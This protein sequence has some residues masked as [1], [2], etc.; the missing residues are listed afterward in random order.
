MFMN[1]FTNK[2]PYTDFHELNLDFLLTSYKHLLDSLR[3]IDKWIEK[4]EHDYAAVLDHLKDLD[5]QIYALD[6]KFDLRIDNLTDEMYALYNEVRLQVKADLASMHIELENIKASLQGMINVEHDSMVRYI[7]ARIEAFINS[8]PD[9][10]DLIIYNPVRGENTLVQVA[11]NDLYNYFN[12]YG[13]T[14]E[15]YDSL[16][17]TATEYDSYDLTA[18]EYD[19]QGYILLGYPDTRWNMRNPFNGL[20]EPISKVVYMLYHL[21][22]PGMTADNYD[23]LE[24]TADA[25]D[26]LLLSAF[27]YDAYGII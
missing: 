27:D 25:Y 22:F 13:L 9:Y 4:H 18:S 17:L 20:I 10:N 16:Q 2:Y 19:S 26:A 5:R 24:L 21:H 1:W 15:Q 7:D 6:K 3:D 14:A 12:A 23:A 11:I 8:L